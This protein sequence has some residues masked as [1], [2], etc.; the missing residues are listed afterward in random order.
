MKSKSLNRGKN[1]IQ[2]VNNSMIMTL[3]QC[4][5]VHRHQVLHTP[6]EVAL[7]IGHSLID[8][9]QGIPTL[10]LSILSQMRMLTSGSLNQVRKT[11]KS[12][13]MRQIRPQYILSRMIADRI[14]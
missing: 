14:P 11:L 1:H 3:L 5:E 2:R 7:L 8:L 6:Q 13:T 12:F 10:T 9:F 4:H